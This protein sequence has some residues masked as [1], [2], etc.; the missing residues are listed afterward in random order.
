MLPLQL[1]ILIES[2]VDPRLFALALGPVSAVMF[3]TYIY[4]RY[5]NTDKSYQFESRTRI[6]LENIVHHDEYSRHISRTR[7]SSVEGRQLSANPRQR[8]T[9]RGR[10]GWFS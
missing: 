10:F 8:L 2:D 6:E 9:A 5:R 1:M 3:F 7:N 4:R